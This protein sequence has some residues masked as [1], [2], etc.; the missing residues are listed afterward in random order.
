MMTELDERLAR[1]FTDVGLAEQNY[2]LLSDGIVDR[3]VGL[4]HP[5][6]GV[7]LVVIEDDALANAVRAHLAARGARRFASEDDV[8]EAVSNGEW[9]PARAVFGKL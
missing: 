4:W 3:R 6:L 1:L 7:R 2:F 5:E 9:P 8:A